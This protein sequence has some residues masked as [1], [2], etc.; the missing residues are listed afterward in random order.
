MSGG[1]RFLT[2]FW[3]TLK[4]HWDM[5]FWIYNYDHMWKT[6]QELGNKLSPNKRTDRI[7]QSRLKSLYSTTKITPYS[8]EGEREI[9]RWSTLCLWRAK[10]L[11][12][13]LTLCKTIDCSPPD[14]SVHE[15]LQTRILEGVAMPSSRGSSKPGD[16]TCISYVFCIGRPVL[17]H[18]GHLGSPL[19]RENTS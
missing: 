2:V 15:I 17:Y 6:E 3:C 4:R 5:Y 9:L 13:C 12:S 1:S 19:L 18:K 8:W 7:G 11:Q 14:S 10:S 16:W